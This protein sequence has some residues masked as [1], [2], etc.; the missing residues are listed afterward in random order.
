M[1]SFTDKF[2]VCDPL[3]RS[4]EGEM[5]YE[6]SNDKIANS[7][8]KVNDLMEIIKNLKPINCKDKL[9]FMFED[10]HVKKIMDML[11]QEY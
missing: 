7:L 11:H 8:V 4:F 3:D 10:D 2:L 1:H 6:D 9:M 5:T